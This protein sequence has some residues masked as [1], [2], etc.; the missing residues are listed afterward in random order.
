MG[1]VLKISHLAVSYPYGFN[2]EKFALHDLDL[3]IKAG[4]IFGLLGPNGAGKT[5]LIKSIVGL[6]NIKSGAIELFGETGLSS[7]QKA[8]LGY[9]PEIAN[10]YWYMTAA[11]ILD[12]F[13]RL[14]HMDR[15]VLKARVADMLRLVGLAEYSDQ[16]VRTFS[17]GMQVRLNIAQ[18][19]M[20]DPEFFILDEPFS[21]LD[22][23][24]R[25]DIRNI[26]KKMKEEGKTILLSSHELSEA[27]L[28]CDTACIMRE[29]KILKYGSLE[30]LLAEKGEHSLENYFI[31]I[32]TEENA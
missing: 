24:G 3:E 22:P 5:T 4:E 10:Y 27:E 2:K 9:M 32:I 19:L 14:C 17:K 29:G 11:E 7:S 8:R 26:L 16:L 25:I 1:D 30:M 12:M 13:G 21:G 23:L 31:K 15:N 6:I 20:H 28:I 18:A